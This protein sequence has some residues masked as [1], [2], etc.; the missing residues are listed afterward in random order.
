[1]LT[2]QVNGILK[3]TAEVLNKDLLSI[4][5]SPADWDKVKAYLEGLNGKELWE[6]F[7]NVVNRPVVK[8]PHTKATARAVG[9]IRILRYAGDEIAARLVKLDGIEVKDDS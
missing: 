6:L 9:D 5:K 4:H 1:M 3:K 7:I 2:I 8:S